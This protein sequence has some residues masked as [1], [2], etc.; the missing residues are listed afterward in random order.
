M[1]RISRDDVAHVAQLARL[2]LSA[3]ELDHFTHQLADVLGHAEDIAELDL[4]GVE[5]MA[6]P[7]PLKNVFRED[8]VE[9]G[10]DRDEILAAAP[11]VENHM[12][13]VPQVMKDAQ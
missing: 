2:D 13:R 8:V 5:P 9:Q 12:F 6:H 4:E 7:Y 3:A 11:D 1:S 10:S